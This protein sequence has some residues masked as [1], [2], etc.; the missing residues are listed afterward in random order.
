ME[1]SKEP[2]NTSSMYPDAIK[3]KCEKQ[4]CKAFRRQDIKPSLWYQVEKDFLC[5]TWKERNERSL[6]LFPLK[7]KTE[8]ETTKTAGAYN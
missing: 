5:K 2:R 6:N 4:N 7:F 3:M 8:K 1:Q